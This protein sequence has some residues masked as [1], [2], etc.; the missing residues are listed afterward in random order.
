[1]AFLFKPAIPTEGMEGLSTPADPF[2]IDEQKR[3]GSTP[4]APAAEPPAPDAATLE[5]FLLKNFLTEEAAVQPLPADTSD[6][7]IDNIDLPRAEDFDAAIENIVDTPGDGSGASVVADTVSVDASLLSDLAREAI[8]PENPRS[9]VVEWAFEETLANHKE[10][11]DSHGEL[12]KKADLRKAKLEGT[13][14]I[15][16]GLR[17]ADL[18]D[19][20][21]KAADLLLA[22]LRDASLVRAN[23]QETCLVGANMEGANLEGA[24]LE[25]AMGMLPR[26]LAGAN[27]HEASLPAQILEFNAL[28]TFSAGSKTVGRLF[29]TLMVV[30][31]LSFVMIWKTKD[32]Q[33]L[34]DTAIISFLHSPA[35]AAAMP[36]DQI[37]LL[38]PALL[39]ALFLFFLYRL[40]EVWDAV[41]ELPAIFPDGRVLGYNAPRIVRGLLRTHFRWMDQDGH[42]T[43]MVEKS[44]SVL[45]AYCAVPIVLA[46][47]WARYLTAQDF[48]GT[49]LHQVL[50][51]ITVGVA[52]YCSTQIGRPGEKWATDEKPTAPVLVKLRSLRPVTIL[53]TL[54][55]AMSLLA[56]GTIA[57]IPHDKQRAPQFMAADPRRWASSVMWAVGYDPYAELTEASISRRPNDWSGADDQVPSVAGARLNGTKFRYAQAYGIFLVNAHLFKADLQ[58]AF[59][60]GSDLRNADLGQANL[61]FAILDRANLQ[62][63]NL[64]RAQLDGA[65]FSR[66]DLRGA[67]LSYTSLVGASLPDARLDGA[68][69][70]STNLENASLLRGNLEKADLRE[71]HL[72]NANLE[73]ADLQQS[74]LW[75]AKL[76]GANLRKAQLATAIFIDADLQN[77]DLS[78]AQLNGTVLNGANLQGAIL[79]GADLRGALQIRASQICSTKSRAG[80]IF[81][82]S[83]RAQV[84]SQCGGAPTPKIPQ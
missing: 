1:M 81:D 32:I 48:H 55:I 41:L 34:A 80:A 77:A 24:S 42:S 6:F 61:Q 23:L 74:Y 45:L 9:E 21:L 71:A 46:M 51:L 40:Q 62:H 67:N 76:P 53:A 20:N 83:L 50:F 22:D 29:A 63:A 10:W 54:F 18:Q 31:F 72:A 36:T 19:A 73:G 11:L 7:R 58:G 65:N 49:F 12:G 69:L 26:Q 28:P 8:L 68:S 59:L 37:Y 44:F 60:S 27:L 25:T 47:Y 13:E 39:V 66:T 43:R 14:L 38:A 15:G 35:A 52:F 16:V 56:A 30:S 17:Y 2:P 4:A 75:S 79:D 84:D 64:D 78:G 82:E 3:S 57:G 33:L 70:Y 5:E